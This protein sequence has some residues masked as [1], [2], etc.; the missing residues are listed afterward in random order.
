M[1]PSGPEQSTSTS[2]PSAGSS[3]VKD[4]ATTLSELVVRAPDLAEGQYNYACALARLG[5]TQGA[6]DHLKAAV[7][8]D[9][10]LAQN[11]KEDEDLKVL[12]GSPVFEQLLKTSPAAGK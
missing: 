11:A 5:D 9:G 10:D 7:K 4:A 1:T 2:V 3:W 8:L 12:R 6:L